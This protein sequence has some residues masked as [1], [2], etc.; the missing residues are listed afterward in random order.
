MRLAIWVVCGALLA[1]GGTEAPDLEAWSAEVEAL[2]SRVGEYRQVAPALA[3]QA[4]CQRE[5]QRYRTDLE[6][7]LQHLRALSA[8][9]DAC[10]DAMGHHDDADLAQTCRS[11]DAELGRHLSDGCGS[12]DAASNQADVQAHCDRML[13]FLE[14]GMLRARSMQGMMGGGMMSGGMCH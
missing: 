7:R 13:G 9:M 8:D 10:M 5:R 12:G 11:M 2:Q 6:P 3:T 1:C 14:R 4:D